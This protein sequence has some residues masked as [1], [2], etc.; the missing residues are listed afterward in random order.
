MKIFSRTE[1]PEPIR[2]D[3]E[4]FQRPSLGRKMPRLEKRSQDL[5][6][7]W[8]ERGQDLGYSGQRRPQVLGFSEQ[9]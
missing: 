4:I 2:P 3:A 6:H 5:R 7:L 9:S 8:A 1:P